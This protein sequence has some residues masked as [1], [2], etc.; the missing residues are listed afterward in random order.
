MKT[1]KLF[2][3]LTITVLLL[4]HACNT[5]VNNTGG[6][7]NTEMDKKVSDLI[8]RMTL[9]EKVGQMTQI[10]LDKFYNKGI[11]D[12]TLLREYIIQY[13]VGSIL[14][15]HN[16]NEEETIALSLEAWRSILSLIQKFAL[17]SK[18]KIPVLYGIDA[19]HGATYLKGATLFPHN[20]TMAATRDPGLVH[21]AAVITAKEVRACGIRWN[22]DPVLGVGRQPLWSRFE[23]TF[24]EDTYLVTE[25]G[26]AA[27][28]GNEGDGLDKNTAVPS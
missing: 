11:L 22:F 7:S 20:I 3:L 2:H 13:G 25:M 16:N 10:T 26:R 23:E 8:S 15:A 5:P 4:T 21:A 18:L 9:E 19:I 6:K 12:T 14:N 1:N 17:E 27:I 24:G 28:T